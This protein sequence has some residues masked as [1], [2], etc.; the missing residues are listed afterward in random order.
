MSKKKNVR[1]EF[2]RT[3]HLLVENAVTN[4]IVLIQALGLCPIIGAGT[5]LQQGVV[6]SVCTAAVMI[7]LSL[8]IALIGSRMP[9]WSRPAAYVVLASLILVGCSFVLDRYVSTELF[10]QLHHFIPLIAVNM[11]YARTTGFSSIVHPVATVMD[12]VGSTLG[13][14]LV[15][16]AVSAIREVMAFGTLW[17]APMHTATLLPQAAAPFS[18]FILLA[19]MAATLQWTRQRISA[20]F[21]RKGEDEE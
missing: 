7:P 15:I 17:G 2:W 18:A 19:F 4:N 9:K 3:A 5:T 20:F 6:L 10:A 21:R 14:G 13:F 8:F 16:C 12:A 11:L 1:R